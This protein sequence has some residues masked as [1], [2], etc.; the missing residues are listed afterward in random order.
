LTQAGT[1][2]LFYTWRE[3]YQNP[4]DSESTRHIYRE[5]DNHTEVHIF[6]KQKK[7]LIF[8][9]CPPE[10]FTEHQV[11]VVITSVSYSVGS[12]FDLI[13]QDDYPEDSLSPTWEM[14]G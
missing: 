13:P 5:R 3:Q 7:I 6:C 4:D 11:W 14:P 8:L 10:V 1:V 12:G 9:V 2:Q